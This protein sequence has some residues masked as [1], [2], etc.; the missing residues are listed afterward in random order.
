VTQSELV[1]TPALLPEE[2][3]FLARAVPTRILEFT[4]GRSC[5]RA[6]LAQLG[7]PPVAIAIGDQRE[8]IWPPGFIG[9][10][11]HC[12]GHCAAA[13]AR[14]DPHTAHAIAS[15]GLDAEPALPLPEDVA[16]MV[17]SDGERKWI[18]QHRQDRLPWDRVVFSAKESVFKCIFPITRQFLDFHDVELTFVG[19]RSFQIRAPS[20]PEATK[21][22]R[23]S[24][25][26]REGFILT[27]A[28]WLAHCQD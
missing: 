28:I 25:A 24:H 3:G 6:A 13:V 11:T 14:W 17:C 26:F 18:E 21:H 7:C 19:E 27:N 23:G 5:A 8:P 4:T 16:G 1:D 22:V 15:L 12:K 9:S 10:I 2:R 20:L